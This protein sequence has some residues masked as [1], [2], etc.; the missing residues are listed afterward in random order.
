MTT[1]D[2]TASELDEA[3]SLDRELIDVF[4]SPK[5]QRVISLFATRPY[6]ATERLSAIQLNETRN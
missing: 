6:H 4:T 3:N 2:V 1:W 5:P